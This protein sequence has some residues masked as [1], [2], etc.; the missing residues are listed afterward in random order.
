M[1]VMRALGIVA[2]VI[3]VAV[4]GAACGGG[5][6]NN[7]AA[8]A[9]TPAPTPT[10]IVAQAAGVWTGV[11]QG[12]S[13]DGGE[14]VG[15]TLAA[16]ADPDTPFTLDVA[17]SGSALTAVSTAPVSGLLTNYSGTAAAGTISLTAAYAVEWARGFS[18]LNGLKRDVQSLSDTINMTVSENTGMVTAAQTYNVFVAGTTTGVGTMT[19]TSSFSV[20]R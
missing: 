1:W 10:P 5:G 11:N 9:P 19:I 12:M 8:T 3:A 18:C 15:V 17:Q 16:M 20:A 14:C 13:V 7:P 4:S 2:L 6:S